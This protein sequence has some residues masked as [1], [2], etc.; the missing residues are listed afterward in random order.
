MKKAVISRPKKLKLQTR[1]TK[2]SAMLAKN[3]IKKNIESSANNS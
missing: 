1:H 2:S 3:N